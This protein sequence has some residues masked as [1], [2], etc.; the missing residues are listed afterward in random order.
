MNA[1]VYAV[2]YV[3]SVAVAPFPSDCRESV[4]TQV[5]RG[6]QPFDNPSACLLHA[7]QKAALLARGR[8][9]PGDGYTVRIACERAQ[10]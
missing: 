7:L 8:D 6:D 5:I 2:I 4:A 9:L 1:V 10:R 3:C